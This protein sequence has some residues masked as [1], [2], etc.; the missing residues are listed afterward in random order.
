MFKHLFTLLFFTLQFLLAG[1]HFLY[2]ED[3]DADK[4]ERYVIGV[5]P[6]NNTGDCYHLLAY[7]LLA[8]HH[9]KEIPE[10]VY[11]YDGAEEL[12]TA[13]SKLNTYSQVE[14]VHTFFAQLGYEKN[15]RI[16][17]AKEVALKRDNPRRKSFRILL[18]DEK[19]THLIDQKLLTTFIVNHFREF[20]QQETV[21]IIRGQ[22]TKQLLESRLEEKFLNSLEDQVAQ[23]IGAIKERMVDQKPLI[24]L[25]ARYSAK[26]K[27]QQN[28]DED[29]LVKLGDYLIERGCLVWF[30]FADGRVKNSSFK[31]VREQRIDVFPFNIEG[32]D[33]GKL[34][35]ISLLLELHQQQ[36][37]LNLKGVIGN[38]SGTL[39]MAAFIGHRVF[40]LHSFSENPFFADDVRLILQSTFMTLQRVVYESVRNALRDAEGKIGPLNE[41]IAQQQLPTLK[42]WLTDFGQDFSLSALPDISEYRLKLGE[43]FCVQS[44]LPAGKIENIEA[45][46][47]PE[48]ICHLKKRVDRADLKSVRR[49]LAL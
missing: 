3:L 15:I 29:F 33:F 21:S 2:L 23:D 47:T 7:M 8:Q 44:L 24:I 46:C 9:Q 5:P 11:G 13:E 30:L 4:G 1:N 27:T 40:N 6:M 19:Y 38:T 45:P 39:D 43:L 20:G 41:D 36:D 31:S 37:D 18:A 49:N 35:H 34:R 12:V 17:K 26:S 28:M 25:H 22:L 48:V 10:I 32:K 14:R 16:V 42:K